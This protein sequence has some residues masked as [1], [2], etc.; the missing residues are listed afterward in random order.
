MA[1]ALWD[2][3]F[4]IDIVVFSLWTR[5]LLVKKRRTF[6]FMRRE[7]KHPTTYFLAPARDPMQGPLSHGCGMQR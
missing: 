1:Y 2:L 6:R 3:V 5:V 4:L 7:S